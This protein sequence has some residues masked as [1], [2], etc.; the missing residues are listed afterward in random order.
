MS[1]TTHNKQIV[2]QLK[3]GFFRLVLRSN[4]NCLFYPKN[5][6]IQN[7]FKSA[8]SGQK[9]FLAIESPLKMMKNAFFYLKAFVL[10]KIFKFF[11]LDFIRKIRLILK[12]MTSQPVLETI[13]IHNCPIFEEVK[14]IR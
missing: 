11:C 8:L 1:W 7:V 4:I 9:Q 12:N 10:L 14:A 5:E 13:L 6:W 3:R 2:F